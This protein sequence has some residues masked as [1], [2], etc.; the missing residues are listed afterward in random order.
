MGS[1]LS[2]GQTKPATTR[3]NIIFIY[4]DDQRYDALG[5]VQNEQG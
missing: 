2:F 1:S 4:T 3:P 5:V